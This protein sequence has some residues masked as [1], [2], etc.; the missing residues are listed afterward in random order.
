MPGKRIGYIRV[1]TLD[2]NPARQLVDVNLDKEFVEFA[3]AKDTNRPQLQLLLDYIRED[4]ELFVHSIDRLAR[5]VKDLHNLVDT[6]VKK[7]V[8]I[9]FVK[10][11]LTFDGNDSHF[12]K[13]SLSILGA[14]AELE[15]E[16]LKER[17]R[18]GIAEA[19]KKGKF[20]GRKKVLDEAKII[21]L[22]EYMRTRKS[23]SQIALDLGI[24]RET[25]Y[26]YLKEL[27]I[28]STF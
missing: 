22:C 4:D 27:N 8:V 25:L 23:K 12:S 17:Q 3:S 1:S 16:I 20:K 5:S 28:P 2:Q 10:Q 19:K 7:G 26:R 24:S 13:F 14:V 18:E 21:L 15:R 11:N 9:H 6:L